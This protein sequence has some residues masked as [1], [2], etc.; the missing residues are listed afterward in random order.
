[1]TKVCFISGS[2][3]GIGLA[4]AR[5]LAMAGYQVILNSRKP[6]QQEVLDQ[7][8]NCPLAVGQAIGNIA[9]FD[10]AKTMI[11]E[12]KAL[13]G[14]L[15]VLINNAGITQDGLFMRMKEADFDAVIE[16]NLNGTFNLCRHAV[17]LMLKQRSGTIINMSSV[18]GITGNAGQVNYAASKAAIIGLTKSLAKELGSRDIRVNAIAPGFIQTDMTHG[19]PERQK[20]AMLANIP[21][22]RFGQVEEV[23]HCVRFLMDNTYMTGQVIEINGGLNM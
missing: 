5:D 8:S 6:F 3:R 18:V 4:I 23:A 1:M 12:V 22:G 21:L 7:F 2:S 15:D 10:Q 20:E 14:S 11:D 9:D 13:Y 16:T 19:I 17:P